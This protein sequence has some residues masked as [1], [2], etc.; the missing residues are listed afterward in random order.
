MIK[1]KNISQKV[2]GMSTR[3]FLKKLLFRDFKGVMFLRASSK[4][5]LMIQA[6]VPRTMAGVTSIKGD[7]F[8]S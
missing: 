5:Q 4:I 3:H 6:Q 8:L 2:L 1:K 7:D